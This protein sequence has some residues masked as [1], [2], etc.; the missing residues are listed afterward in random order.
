MHG[1][2]TYVYKDGYKYQGEFKDNF[3]NGN[4]ILLNE[5]NQFVYEGLFLNGK[6]KENEEYEFNY[7]NNKDLNEIKA[8][9][10]QNQNLD[11]IEE[12]KKES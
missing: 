7:N 8:N 1:R 9:Q 12:E 3:E 6:R 4:G 10:N 2:G 11:K 5:K